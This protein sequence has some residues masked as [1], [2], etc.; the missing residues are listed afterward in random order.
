MMN[1][2]LIIKELERNLGIFEQSL[3]GVSKEEYLWKQDPNRWCLLE[4][5]C[6]LYDEEIEDFRTRT[7]HVLF[8]PDKPFTPIDPVS[9]VDKRKYIKQEYDAVVSKFLEE[10][11]SS[12]IWLHSLVKP[13][14][15]NSCMHVDF[16]LMTAQQFLAN[17]LAHDYLHFKQISKLKMDYLSYISKENFS[18]SRGW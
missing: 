6:H 5:I 12:L 15:N 8:T 17:W 16:G 18:Y 7:S 9:W 2:Q 3:T 11:K 4:I 13:K 1:H 14:W 10:R